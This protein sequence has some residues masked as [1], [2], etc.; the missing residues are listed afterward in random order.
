MGEDAG[1]VQ[2]IVHNK[3]RRLMVWEGKSLSL[4]EVRKW[5]YLNSM[6]VCL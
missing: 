4:C 6:K 2:H 5:K 3:F 1:V